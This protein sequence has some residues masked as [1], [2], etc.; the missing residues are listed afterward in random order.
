M[1]VERL[2]ARAPV[3][4]AWV[5]S[6]RPDPRR[7]DL[8]DSRWATVARRLVSA[9]GLAPNDDPDACRW[10]ALRNQPRKVHIVA[11]PACE[12]GGLHNTHRGVFHVQTEYRRLAAELGHRRPA[13]AES[14]A[15]RGTPRPRSR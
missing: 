7:P 6:V 4:P 15:S 1:P 13:P 8:T 2:G 14:P 12:D 9:V 5:C 3:R 10:I 11:T